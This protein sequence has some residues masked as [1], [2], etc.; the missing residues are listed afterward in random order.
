MTQKYGQPAFVRRLAFIER[1]FPVCA[2]TKAARTCIESICVYQDNIQVVIKTQ[3][4]SIQRDKL[5]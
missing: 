4:R 2:K 1:K 5:P 3:D